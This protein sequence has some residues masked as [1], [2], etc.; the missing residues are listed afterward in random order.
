M[1]PVRN[2]DLLRQHH[3]NPHK[4]FQTEIQVFCHQDNLE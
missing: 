3:R 4:N 1:F 2:K